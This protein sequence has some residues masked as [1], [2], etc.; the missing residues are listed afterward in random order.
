MKYTDR[1]TQGTDW[2]GLSDEKIVCL[3]R[4]GDD[5]ALEYL[6]RKYRNLIESRADRFFLPG[7]GDR[8]DL[9][10]EGMIGFYKAVRKYDPESGS[11]FAAFADLCVTSQIKTAVTS[12]NSKKHEPLNTSVLLEGGM[13]GSDEDR[14][15]R[16]TEIAD[17]T[18]GPEEYIILKE[19][20]LEYMK[21]EIPGLSS[22]EKSVLAL[23]LEGKSCRE[24][25]EELKRPVKSVDNAIQRIKKKRRSQQCRRQ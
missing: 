23:Y 14:V 11:P 25:G 4:D 21:E 13:D 18:P 9:I 19:T 3:M 17:D 5:D 12:Y 2:S 7:G 22:Y 15:D 10:Q 1:G 8:Q 20:P 6:F 24:I 16:G